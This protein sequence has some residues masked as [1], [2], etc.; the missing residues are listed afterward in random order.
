MLSSGQTGLLT[1]V[2]AEEE[3]YVHEQQL[4]YK[5]HSQKHSWLSGHR[6]H[7][8]TVQTFI[9]PQGIYIGHHHSC[10]CTTAR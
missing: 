1:P 3:E 4:V 9:L 7:H 5:H 10:L 8:I 2:K 6:V